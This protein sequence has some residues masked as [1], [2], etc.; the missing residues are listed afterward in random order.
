MLAVD[1]EKMGLFLHEHTS[2]VISRHGRFSERYEIDIGI[3]H[4]HFQEK[5]SGRDAK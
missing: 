5:L 4:L 1:P 2:Y 3:P